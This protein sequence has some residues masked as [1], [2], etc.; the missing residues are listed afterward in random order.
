M[1]TCDLMFGYF[2][3]HLFLS[4]HQ[5]QNKSILSTLD[6]FSS[7]NY[8]RIKEMAPN[9]HFCFLKLKWYFDISTTS[10]PI[11]IPTRVPN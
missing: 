2:D 6:S 11:P 4:K 9:M 1:V 10:K 7:H 5:I 8:E 3:G